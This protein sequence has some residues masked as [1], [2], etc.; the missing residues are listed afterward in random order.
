VIS[1]RRSKLWAGLAG[2]TLAVLAFPV[3]ATASLRVSGLDTSHYPTVRATVMSTGGPTLRPAVSEDGTAV[4]ALQTLNLAA[5]KSVVLAIDRSRSMRGP[6]FSDAVAAAKSFVAS[7]PACDEVAVDAFGSGVLGESRFSNDPGATES[8]LGTLRIDPHQGTAL[9]DAVGVAARQLAAHDGGRVLILLTDGS[10]TSSKASLTWVAQAARSRN[11]LVYPIAIAGRSYDPTALKQLADET[12][13][14]FYRANTSGSLIDVYSSIARALRN[15]WRIEYV[16]AARPGDE[17][18]V[19]AAA[20]GAGSASAA[21]RIPASLGSA[22]PPPASKLVPAGAYG[23]GGP[24]VVGIAVCALSLLAIVLVLAA[25][26]GSWVRGRIAAHIGETRGNSKQKRRERRLAA[27]STMFHATERAFGHLKQWRSTQRMLERAD[28]PL[29]TV[30]FFWIAV[31]TAFGLGIVAALAGQAALIVLVV[32]ALGATLPFLFVWLKMRR[33]LSAFENQLP[34]LLVTVAASLKAGHSFK[35][36]LQAVVDEGQPP[37]SDEF[38]RVLMETSLGR[39]MDEALTA[40]AERVGSPN[41][42]FA[43]TAVTIQR[44]IGGSLASLFDMVADTVRQRQAFSRKIK[45]LTAMG[46]MS[47]YT[48]MGLPFFIALMIT[49]INPEYMSPLYHTATGHVMI[50]GGL[51]MMAI[52][53]ALLKRIVSFRG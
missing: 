2:V 35:Q 18:H 9:Y 51:V 44:Q 12:G 1:A 23:P 48:L 53:S 22:T 32:M 37:A 25:H 34:D 17:I 45:S 11:V 5:C 19:Q 31:G 33:R 24:L 46:R 3:A 15:T 10:D 7:K 38:K 8:A 28:L 30:E 13:G 41:F 16:T 47:S 4:A 21:T 42:E 43:I 39:P 26:R 20:A 52:G 36:G 27:L 50:I 6:S 49:L 40:M 29:K 14:A